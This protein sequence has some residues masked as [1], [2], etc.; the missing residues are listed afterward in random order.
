MPTMGD[1]QRLLVASNP[2]AQG[3]Q[4]AWGHNPT[5]CFDRVDKVSRF[6]TAVVTITAMDDHVRCW[7]SCATAG[8]PIS[9]DR[10]L[11]RGWRKPRDRGTV[12]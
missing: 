12:D 2:S 10:Q 6:W 8:G 5:L 1:V 9:S 4:I 7:S 11:R 3:I